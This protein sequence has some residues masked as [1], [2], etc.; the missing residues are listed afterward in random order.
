MA[1]PSH[2][3]LYRSPPLI[4]GG[5]LGSIVLLVAGIAVGLQIAEQPSQRLPL[6]LGMLGV[7][8]LTFTVCGLAGLRRHRWTIDAQDVLIE[9]RPLVPMFGRRRLRRVPFGVIASLGNAG[10]HE[11]VL[12]TRVGERFVLPAG[13]G[14]RGGPVR[15][16]D[17][18]E[19]ATFAA[20][21]QAAM[22]T[23]GQAAPPVTDGLG[24]FSRPPGLVLLSIAFVASLAVAVVV[25]WGLWQG[26]IVR[27]KTHEAA[28]I[29][30]ALPIAVGWALRL[31]W[32]RRRAVLRAAS[33]SDR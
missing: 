13:R 3:A 5:F 30:V 27:V 16:L 4:L 8:V 23:A 21:L 7:F 10:A 25:L 19:L 1:A 20:R 24:F 26:A 29:L 11:L 9:E 28:A 32:Q 17:R 6:V 14:P 31:G 15:A 22:T 2:Q 18:Q 12:T 33:R